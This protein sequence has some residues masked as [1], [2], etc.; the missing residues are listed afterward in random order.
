M[1]TSLAV[2]LRSTKA[3]N[4]PISPE[5]YAT[6]FQE[7]FSNAL[8][9]YFNTIDNF[10]GVLTDSLGG[11]KIRFPYGAF[12]DTTTQTTTANTA[13]VVTFNT[14]DFSNGIS[15]VSGSKLTVAVPGI[16][17]LQFSVQLQSTENATTDTSIWLR[18]GNDGGASA[19]IVGSTGLL[20]MPPRQSAFN[21]YHDIKGWNYFIS[22]AANDY[23]QIYWSTTS[24]NVTITEYAISASPTRPSTA[25]VVATMSF[26]SAI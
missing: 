20:G 5:E 8:R 9:L 24:A 22:M 19:D 21:P 18:Q 25:S 26:V 4:L 23:V 6:Q 10:T 12:Q 3:P 7:Q 17:N 13:K 1:A 14:T 16:Y 15:L 2:L 11:S